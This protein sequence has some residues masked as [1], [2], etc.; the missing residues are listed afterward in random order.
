MCVCQMQA[1][2][3]LSHNLLCHHLKALA[4]IGLVSAKKQGRFTYYGLRKKDYY[5]FKINLHII[6]GG[7]NV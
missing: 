5:N 6:L 7:K 3:G 4:K 1:Q 2:L